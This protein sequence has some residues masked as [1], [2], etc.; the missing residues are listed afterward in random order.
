M[1]DYNIE[2]GHIY[3]D[4][5]PKK[6]QTDS[7]RILKELEKELKRKRKKYVKTIL[8]DDLNPEKSI[9]NIGDYSAGLDKAGETDFIFLE[10]FLN[11]FKD[12]M[13]GDIGEDN[14][15]KNNKKTFM[16]VEGGNNILLVK[17]SG[18]GTCNFLVA[19]WFLA[20]LGI[21]K[22]VARWGINLNNKKFTAEKIITILSKKYESS[23]EQAKKIIE[24]TQYKNEIENMEF[25]YFTV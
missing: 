21:Y 13:L 9:L 12:K 11:I 15:I 5:N 1:N 7:L 2:F 20:R 6:E 17:E 22:D 14:L 19:I 8:I 18:L 16:K 25:I 10:S 23:D 3:I 24:K 4:Q